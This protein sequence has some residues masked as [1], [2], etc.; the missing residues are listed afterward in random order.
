MKKILAAGFAGLA[1]AACDDNQLANST[2]VRDEA[3]CVSTADPSACRQALADARV[4]H[5]KTAPQFAN[6]ETC[7]AKF[8]VDNCTSK[9]DAVAATAPSAGSGGGSSGGGSGGSGGGT[10]LASSGEGHGMF[11]PMMMGFMM[12][13]MMGRMTGQPVYRDINNTAFSG[14]KQVGKFNS[15]TTPPPRAPGAPVQ[16]AA[17]PRQGG[18]AATAPKQ[19]GG[20]GFGGFRRR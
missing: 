10:Q 15:A 18:G 7:E 17:A 8:G 6:K 1:L 14:N 3:Q 11:M 19:S 5:V 16:S 13:Q 4:E 2:F 20:K 12:G 9:A